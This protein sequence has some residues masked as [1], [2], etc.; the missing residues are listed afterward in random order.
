MS[1]AVIMMQSYTQ[2]QV[3]GGSSCY[4]SITLLALIITTS[5]TAGHTSMHSQQP[6]AWTFTTQ[7]VHRLDQG[8]AHR[9]GADV[10]MTRTMEFCTM[11]QLPLLKRFMPE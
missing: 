4:V 5:N 2:T 11:D 1:G 3:S 9:N 7:Q 8:L 6:Q 10:T